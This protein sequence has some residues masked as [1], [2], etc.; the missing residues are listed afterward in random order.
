MNEKIRWEMEVDVVRAETWKNDN[1]ASTIKR[2]KANVTS[3]AS[4]GGFAA[5]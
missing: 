1:K 5:E 2:A 3:A 4:L